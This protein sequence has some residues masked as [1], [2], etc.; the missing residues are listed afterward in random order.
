[1]TGNPGS[2]SD[3]G[4]ESQEAE[5]VAELAAV[6]AFAGRPAPSFGQLVGFGFGSV[7]MG[8]WVT[9]PGLL[10]LFYLTN[11][12]G[13]NPFIAGL[14]LLLPK[15][16]DIV[17]HPG[18]GSLSDRQLAKRGNR[19]GMMFFGLLLGIAMTAMFSVPTA[20]VGT[21]AALWV[22]VFYT[23]GNVSFASFQVPYITTPSDLDVSYYQ[24]TRVMTF[25]MFLLIVG[26]LAAGVAAPALVAGGT[27][28]EYTQMAISLGI[29]MFVTALVAI[30]SIKSLKKFMTSEHPD[31]NNAHLPLVSGVRFAW[32]DRNFRALV[33]SYL[34]TGATTHLFLAALPF[35]AE[36]VF[37]NTKVTAIFMGAFLGPALIAT[38]VW[39]QVSKR[40]GKQR[41]LLICQLVFALGALS[42]LLGPTVGLGPTVVIVVVL[43]I[44]FAGLQ[45]FAY[46]MVPDVARA[47]SPDGSKAGSYTG[48]WTATEAT[49]TAF[50]PYIYAAVLGLGGFV[51]STA[52]DNVT[53]TS[54]AQIALLLG[55]TVV[56]AILMVIAL[57]FQRRYQLGG[58]PDVGASTS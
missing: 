4:V 2:G 42:L 1:M 43:G 15:L 48:V 20:L 53:Q 37:H 10:L 19:R 44:C 21:G 29:V 32:A 46:S 35:F 52:G 23:L 34:F 45:L 54:S 40:I 25:R 36:Y 27:R 14:T 33:L 31:A 55:F 16:L 13:V 3:S 47:A 8:V 39:L 5:L 12:V 11:V 6:E 49:G 28:A 26:L 22:A 50:G 41:G 30:A 9:V 18:F 38:P 24:R 56:P 51:A 58:V 17:L 7:G 57:S